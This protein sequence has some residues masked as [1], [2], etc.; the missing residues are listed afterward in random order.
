MNMKLVDTNTLSKM[1]PAIKASS[2]V[3][4]RH[5]G[6]G[7]RFVKLGNRVFYDIDDVEAWFE[8]NKVSSTAEA[9]N[10]NH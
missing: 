8:S 1:F 3:S 6:V 2:W 9:A 7:P 4:M 5:R 10:R